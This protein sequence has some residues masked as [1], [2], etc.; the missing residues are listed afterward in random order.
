MIDIHEKAPVIPILL[1][2][3]NSSPH[4]SIGMKPP[5]T[6][7]AQHTK[8]HQHDDDDNNY[9]NKDEYHT[10]CMKN[11]LEDSIHIDSQ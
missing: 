1:Y 10:I 3:D 6:K 2:S 7:Y 8:V 5:R 9:C 4:N 11:S